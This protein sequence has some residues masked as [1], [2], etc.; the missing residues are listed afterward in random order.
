MREITDDKLADNRT[1]Y[2][3]R[4]LTVKQLQINSLLEVSQAIN[5]NFSTSALFR[6]YEFILRA[7][8]G[9]Q[10]LQV[11]IKDE[12]WECVCDSGI[13][14]DSPFLDVE[15]DL[16]HYRSITSLKGKQLNSGLNDFDVIIPVYH[17]DHALAYV[18]IGDLKT[19]DYD[20]QEEKLKFIQTITNIVIVAVEN[21]KLFA[22]QVQQEVVKNE[23]A[24]AAKVQAMLIP[25]DL[26]NNEHLEMAAE[27]QPHNDI[28]GD[29][30]D[31]FP[32]SDEETAFCIGDISGKGVAAALLMSNFQAT[33]RSL[34]YQF[35]ALDELTQE[36]NHRVAQIT[37]GEKFITIFLGIYNHTTR[38]LRYVNAGHNPSILIADGKM[39]ELESGCTLLGMFDELPFVN[40]GEVD[41][42]KHAMLFN[43]TDGLLDFENEKGEFYSLDR[44]ER[45]LQ[46]HS[47][48]PMEDLVTK[49]MDHVNEYRGNGL[50]IDDITVLSCRFF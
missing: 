10:R 1:E 39:V 27:Y 22:K 30:Y 38:K 28:G 32:L 36:L 48:E 4:L 5:N 47:N 15:A 7:Q 46:N 37:Q 40:P 18:L 6:I 16:I 14:K 23:L 9:I 44:V 29:Y 49:L 34:A 24:L 25:S 41:I 11:Y 12:G 2:M 3:E 26:P 8:M 50:F 42:P 43:Y 19:D 33:M 31:C 21:K 20:S 45:F 13:G 17:K 35:T